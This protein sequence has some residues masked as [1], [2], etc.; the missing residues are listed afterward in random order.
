[1]R[2]D[3][4]FKS[5]LTALRRRRSLLNAA[6]AIALVFIVGG[7][8]ALAA[9]SLANHKKPKPKP[10]PKLTLNST[11]KSFINSAIASGHVAF[12]TSAQTASSATT[13][14]TATSATNATSAKSADTA[15]NATSLGGVAASGY[16]RND[17]ASTT[18]Q[19][20]GFAIVEA[21]A[22]FS[23]TL[24]GVGG[25]NCSGQAVQAARIG[26]GEYEVKFLGSPAT[27]AVGNL[28]LP[29]NATPG[30]VAF[31]SIRNLGPGDFDVLIY[32]PLA[33]GPT[34]LDDQPFALMTP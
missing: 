20:K 10:K 29:S 17:C 13:A 3:R 19:V 2:S 25:Y 34:H 31:L 21:S 4:A 33:P 12:A 18:G 30:I 24:T 28:N 11:D 16:T 27:I 5:G 7:G 15:T 1:M 9:T 32:N 26:P 6:T 8:S 22:G 23:G 14:T